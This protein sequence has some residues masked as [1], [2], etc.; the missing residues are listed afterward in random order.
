[1]DMMYKY[2]EEHDNFWIRRQWD[3]NRFV[4]VAE[5]GSVSASGDPASETLLITS[6]SVDGVA[7]G[8][9]IEDIIANVQQRFTVKKEK[10]R[11]NTC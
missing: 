5:E 1:M 3:G 7:I 11:M 6:N 2:R 8:E 10:V 9:K 4:K